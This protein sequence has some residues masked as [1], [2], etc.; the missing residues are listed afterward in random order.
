MT[1][2]NSTT[3]HYVR[4]VKPNDKKVPDEFLGKMCLLQLRYSGVFEAVHIRQTGFP[5]RWTHSEFIERYKLLTG[6]APIKGTTPIQKCEDILSYAR[7]V[8][9]VQMGKTRVLYRAGAHRTLELLRVMEQERRA[10]VIQASIRRMIARIMHKKIVKLKPKVVAALKTRNLMIIDPLLVQC[11]EVAFE[12]GFIRDLRTMKH[13]LEEEKKIAVVMQE[14]VK[15]DVSSHYDEYCSIINQADEIEM[16]TKL[17]N[18]MREILNLETEKREIATLLEEGIKVLDFDLL[19]EAVNRA[20]GIKYDGPKVQQARESLDQAE[21]EKELA[22]EL[23]KAMSTGMCHGDDFA[24]IEVEDL[25]NVI[26]K[27]E[28]TNVISKLAKDQLLKANIIY[29]IRLCL[30]GEDWET[31]Q[32]TILES[33]RADLSENEEIVHARQQLALKAAKDD[34]VEA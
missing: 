1:V 25:Q 12:T 29:K 21:R 10:V 31:L 18:E 4:C 7:N 16:K 23:E 28:S 30:R 9:D 26:K 22:A 32:Q 11:D 27:A 14:L 13:R 34:V 20:N 15:K 24:S 5:F 6:K 2:L 19:N 17:A 33:A 3:P 8:E